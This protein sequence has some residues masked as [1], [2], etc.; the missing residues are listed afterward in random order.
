MKAFFRKLGRVKKRKAI[1]RAVAG[2][3]AAWALKYGRINQTT[4]LFVNY[5]QDTQHNVFIGRNHQ[6]QTSEALKYALKVRSGAFTVNEKFE[7]TAIKK[8]AEKALE[9][10]RLKNEYNRIKKSMENGTKPVDI[11]RR[12]IVVPGSGGTKVLIKCGQGRYFVDFSEDQ[13]TILGI[14]ARSNRQDMITFK[15]L[16]NKLYDVKIN[17]N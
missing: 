14:S 13:V 16:M 17:Y 10:P 7:S 12:S 3:L 6:N 1:K 5:G 4:D 15:N 9:N 2:G 8:L 11:S